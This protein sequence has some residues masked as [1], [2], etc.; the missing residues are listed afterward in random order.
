LQRIPNSYLW[1]LEA[2]GEKKK[3]KN[4]SAVDSPSDNTTGNSVE[5][6]RRLSKADEVVERNLY[7]TAL[8]YGISSNRLIF[9]KRTS[10]FTHIERHFAAD[11]FLDSFIYSAHST[12]TDSLRGVGYCVLIVCMFSFSF[13][14]FLG[15]TCINCSWKQLP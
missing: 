9:A 4:P 11:L 15:I 13:F 14:S 3:F 12:A 5:A 10:K 7:R 1:L 2:S 8:L 6:I